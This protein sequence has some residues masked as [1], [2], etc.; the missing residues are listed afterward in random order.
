MNV[1]IE[2]S[3]SVDMAR[4]LRSLTQRTYWERIWIIQEFLLARSITLLCGTKELS[5]TQLK[6][7]SDFL[8]RKAAE[9]SL[10]SS[11]D[12]AWASHICSTRALRLVSDKIAVEHLPVGK[13]GFPLETMVENYF[14]MDCSREHDKV[15]ALLGLIL[16]KEFSTRPNVAVDYAAPLSSVCDETLKHVFANN[17]HP[18]FNEKWDFVVRLRRSLKC[19]GQ[20]LTPFTY[21]SFL[22]WRT[23]VSRIQDFSSSSKSWQSTRMKT[24]TA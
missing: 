16:P 21:D 1:A 12:P 17:E 5:W 7:A 8:E 2:V 22:E 9:D 11:V 19:S 24:Q 15:Y 10:E 18:T 13:N 3:W 4:A 20:P 14:D 6:Q 23:Q